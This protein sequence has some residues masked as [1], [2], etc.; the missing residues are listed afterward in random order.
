MLRPEGWSGAGYG[1]GDAR[2][3]TTAARAARPYSP[4]AAAYSRCLHPLPGLTPRPVLP[5]AGA[6]RPAESTLIITVMAADDAG[7]FGAH[8]RNAEELAGK[9]RP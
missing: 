2:L 7:S 8:G 1:V 9:E 5:P 4:G 3:G 6:E